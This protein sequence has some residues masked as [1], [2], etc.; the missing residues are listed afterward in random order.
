[1]SVIDT[2]IPAQSFE[3]VRDRIGQII[4]DELTHQYVLTGNSNLNAKVF[5]ERFIAF[6]H[7]E[8]PAVNVLFDQEEFVSRTA[9]DVQGM[10]RY[11][12][13][14]YM[15]SKTDADERGDV[16]AMLALQRLLGVIRGIIMNPKYVT[17]GFAPPFVWD[18]T[19]ES[20]KIADPGRTPDATNSVMGR[21]ILNVKM[22]EETELIAP[23]LAAGFDTQVRLA[24]TENGF[25]YVD[26]NI[27]SY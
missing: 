23:T 4:K 17:L 11:I 24:E 26:D 18:R 27:Y 6:G 22:P 21:I 10:S 3:I 14:G 15:K 2:I 13:E 5:V 12:I 25:M 20:I 9:I 7:S 8:L 1:M 16:K 19:I